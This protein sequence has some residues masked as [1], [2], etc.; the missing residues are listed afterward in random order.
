MYYPASGIDLEPILTASEVADLFIYVDYR[1]KWRDERQEVV[2]RMQDTLNAIKTRDEHERGSNSN[3]DEGDLGFPDSVF[4]PLNIQE[5]EEQIGQ[6]ETSGPDDHGVEACLRNQLEEFNRQSSSDQLIYVHDREIVL[7]DIGVDAVGLDGIRRY[8]PSGF[9]MRP[10]EQR[11]YKRTWDGEPASIAPWAREIALD[12]RIGGQRRSITLTYIAGEGIA[13]Y[14]ALYRSGRIAPQVLIT[15]HS[16][17]LGAHGFASLEEP[18]G[19]MGRLLDACDAKPER[20]ITGDGTRE[21][22][23]DAGEWVLTKYK[24]GGTSRQ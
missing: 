19:I 12:C 2:Q 6:V 24:A 5:M 9:V 16:F 18:T 20:W 22:S 11:S 17:G 23:T 15:R 13:T 4:R 8:A 10:S 1:A 21:W 3:A 7:D 14:C